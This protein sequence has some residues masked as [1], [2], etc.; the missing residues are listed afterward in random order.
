VV[1]N[2]ALLVNVILLFGAMGLFSTVLTLPGIAG[3][4]LTLGMAIDA[5]VLIYER[6]REE[7]VNNKSLRGAVKAA[8]EKAFP[9]IFDSNVTTLITALILFWKASGPVKG[10]AVALIIGIVSTLFTALV[11]TRNLFSWALHLGILKEISMANLIRATKFDFM[12]WRR[13]AI[14]G[15][16]LIMAS[17]V[18]IFALRGDKN[19]GVD[20]KGGDRVVLEAVKTKPDIAAVRAVV[21]GLKLG[22]VAVQIEKSAKKEFFTV[23]GP[24]ESGETITATL[25]QK[26]P[27]AEFS[28]ENVERVGSLVGG[29]MAR[30]ALIALTL[31]MLGIL[32]YVTIR[33]EFSFALGALVALMHDVII[34]IGVF[35]LLGRE[36]SLVTVGAVLTIAGYSVNDTIVVFDRIRESLQTGRKGSV[37]EIMNLSINE[38]LSRTM[39]TGGVTLLTTVALFFFGGPVL[40]DFALTILIG[41][42]VGTYSSVFVASPIVLWWSGRRGSGLREEVVRAPIEGEASA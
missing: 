31:G 41:V 24:K 39:I 36:L 3:V 42:L 23:R 6:L 11:A 9:A 20:F 2:L 22:E 25:K 35:A 19:F 5:N 7:M 26:F 8:F 34:T 30:N 17:S 29:E 27:E 1:A 16:L 32:V 13:T 14:A 33:F 12:G 38:T 4:I 10:F 40:A 21:D 28:L 18:G 37:S 15:S